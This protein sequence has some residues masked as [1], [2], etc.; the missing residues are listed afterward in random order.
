MAKTPKEARM[1]V[2]KAME[3][4]VDKTMPKFVAGQ[5]KQIEILDTYN[6][7]YA[8]INFTPNVKIKGHSFSTRGIIVQMPILRSAPKGMGGGKI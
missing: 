2:L 3:K 7:H 6:F 1:K 8:A 4:V 5:T